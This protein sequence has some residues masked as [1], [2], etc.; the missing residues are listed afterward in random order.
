MTIGKARSNAAPLKLHSD[1][2][3]PLE[4]IRKQ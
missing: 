4:I 2:L 1:F 3:S